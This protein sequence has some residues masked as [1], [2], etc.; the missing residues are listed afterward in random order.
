MATG[1]AAE[2]LVV[3]SVNRDLVATVDHLPV[4]GET[5]AGAA[6]AE[7]LGGKG[8][9]QAVAA[10]RAGAR[11]ALLATVGD[12]PGGGALR[13]RLAELGVGTELVA[14]AP[15]PSGTALVAVDAAGENQIVVVPGANAATG[16]ERVDALVPGLAPSTVVVVQ[17][18]VPLTT[19]VT[20]V[21]AGRAAGATV[22]VN[23]APFVALP[24]G[25]LSGCVVVVNAV[26]LGQLLRADPP[27]TVEAARAAAAAVVAGGP[28]AVVVSLGADGAVWVTAEGE[29]GHVAAP[30]ASAVVDT[31]GAGDALVG[32]LAAALAA[33]RSLDAVVTA[34]VAAATASVAH[35][36][37]AEGYPPFA[38]GAAR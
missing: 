4:A 12:D 22:V 21:G 15:G 28:A 38:V 20:A 17:G 25:V 35:P 5:V 6:L 32:V 31:T 2:V 24:P 26:E 7:G 33:G 14:T 36:G 1:E 8:A 9:N 13:A 3:G 23:L 18:E 16:P 27:P 29:G 34:A 10:A 37:A 30:P 11:V 19:I